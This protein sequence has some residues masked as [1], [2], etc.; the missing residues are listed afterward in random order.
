MRK[1]ALGCQRSAEGFSAPNQEGCAC[2]E[3]GPSEGGHK[4]AA[5]VPL[6][7]NGDKFGFAADRAFS[8]AS[9]TNRLL[10]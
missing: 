10:R 8:L 4:Y 1:E 6:K 9:R 2:E 3:Q 5:L 7:Q